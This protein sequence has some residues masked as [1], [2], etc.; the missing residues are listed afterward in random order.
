MV[1]LKTDD[2]TT[3]ALNSALQM[4]CILI[5]GTAGYCAM[6]F[7]DEKGCHTAIGGNVHS[8]VYQGFADKAFRKQ[9]MRDIAAQLAKVSGDESWLNCDATPDKAVN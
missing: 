2:E 4:L 7:D 3:Q 6:F 9:L 5:G 8:T 1:M